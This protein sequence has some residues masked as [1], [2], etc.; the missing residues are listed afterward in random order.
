MSTTYTPGGLPIPNDDDPFRLGAQR[1][2]ELATAIDGKGVFGQASGNVVVTSPAG[3]VGSTAVTFPARRF[4]AAPY[5]TT[6]ASTSVPGTVVLSTSSLNQTA[7]GC[8]IYGS[9]T[10]TTSFSVHWIAMQSTG[11]GPASRAGMRSLLRAAL[12]L[13][14]E[15]EM[16]EPDD[17]EVPEVP[18]PPEA[19]MVDDDDEGEFVR[20]TGTCRTPGC[21][22]VDW[23]VTLFV[24]APGTLPWTCGVCGQ[25]IAD[26][27]VDAQ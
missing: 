24:P 9:R 8:T 6:S 27:E 25:L 11:G 12:A 10:T 5:V 2:R 22:N 15:G 23:P 13:D 26:T 18:E 1:I 20:M 21:G 16:Q 17:H 4:T 14:D 3:G 19:P 7:S